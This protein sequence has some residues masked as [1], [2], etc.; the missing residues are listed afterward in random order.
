MG[1]GL[2]EVQYLSNTGGGFAKKVK[3]AIGTT[4]GEFFRKFADGGSDPDRHL[5][6][7]N[8]QVASVDDVLTD[9][10]IVSVTPT[11]VRGS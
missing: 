9:G 3:V 5:I 7:V 6:Q 2:I 11:D 10:A 4:V 8:R 1:A